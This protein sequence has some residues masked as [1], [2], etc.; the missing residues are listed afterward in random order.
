[1]TMSVLQEMRSW[2][3]SDGINV[4]IYVSADFS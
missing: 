2:A 4:G 3:G 1:M